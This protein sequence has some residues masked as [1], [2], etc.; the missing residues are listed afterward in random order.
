ML[1]SLK[2]MSKG[3]ETHFRSSPNSFKKVRGSIRGEGT[4]PKWGIEEMKRYNK[5]FKRGNWIKMERIGVKKEGNNRANSSVGSAGLKNMEKVIT[6]GQANITWHKTE[7]FE[8]AR[9]KLQIRP[10]NYLLGRRQNET[11]VTYA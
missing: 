10:E 7:S 11:E 4:R 6:E 5:I 2:M 8:K 1:K 9:A 3:K